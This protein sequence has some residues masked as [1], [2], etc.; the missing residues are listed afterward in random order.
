MLSIARSRISCR[1]G[2]QCAVSCVPSPSRRSTLGGPG[3]QVSLRQ[4]RTMGSRS[5]TGEAGAAGRGDDGLDVAEGMMHEAE[6][7]DPFY[8]ALRAV[9]HFWMWFFFKRVDVRHLERMPAR[10]PVLLC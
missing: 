10:G 2:R 1:T 4:C 7:I 5:G 3:R 8:R 9:G 6:P